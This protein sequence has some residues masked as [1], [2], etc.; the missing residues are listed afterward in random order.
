M[1]IDTELRVIVLLIKKQIKCSKLKK[2]QIVVYDNKVS[3]HD[4]VKS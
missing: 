2:S 1:Q 4:Y 3:E